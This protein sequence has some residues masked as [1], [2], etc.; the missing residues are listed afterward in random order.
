[1]GCTLQSHYGDIIHLT[2]FS[3]TLVTFLHL[4]TIKHLANLSFECLL[5]A[6]GFFSFIVIQVGGSRIKF[7]DS[8]NSGSESV[9]E[10]RS[11]VHLNAAESIFEAFMAS[12]GQN[13]NPRHGSYE[14]TNT[15]QGSYYNVNTQRSP[16]EYQRSA[17]QSPY[18]LNAQEGP[19]GNV[20]STP[21][22]AY[23]ITTKQSAYQY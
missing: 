1:M 21:Q 12:A 13:T 16:Y 20:N 3:P 19:Y 11:S 23:H 18:Q 8:Y 5:I 4:G 14:N 17:H 9:A 10:M 2:S 22:G 15:H 6:R 7:Q